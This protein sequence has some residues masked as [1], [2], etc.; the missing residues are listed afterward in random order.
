MFKKILVC[1]D[2]SK[3]AEEILPYV[4]ESCSGHENEVILLQVITAHI[5]IPPPES[6]HAM[7]FGIDSKPDQIHT[8][9]IGKTT[10]LEP[11][12]NLQFREIEREQLE[13]NMHLESMAQPLRGRGLKV[14]TITLPGETGETILNYAHNQ[15]A[16][17]IALTTH[18]NGGLKRGTLGHV[19]QYILKES[20]IPVLAVKPK[21]TG[22]G[23]TVPK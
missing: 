3:L 17:L 15:K 23:N 16:S 1:M 7:T 14:K 2:G 19:A 20:E 11:K 22:G 12:T 9:D 5:T 4:I 6:T 10:T 18:G 8:T 13:A 21:G